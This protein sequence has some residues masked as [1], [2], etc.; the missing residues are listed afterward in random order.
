MSTRTW[1][2]EPP[3][4]RPASQLAGYTLGAA[5]AVLLWLAVY[6]WLAWRLYVAGSAPAAALNLML[7]ALLIVSGV[8]LALV[9]WEIVRRWWRQ[10][11]PAVWGALSLRQMQALTPSEF[12][13]YVA[14]RLFVRQGYH[15]VNTP[16]VKDGGVDVILTDRNGSRAVVQCKR[17]KGTVGEE[18]VRDLYGTMMHADAE[19][20]YLVTTGMISP[21]AYRWAVG[22]PIELIDG[23]RLVELAR[24]VPHNE[25]SL[26]H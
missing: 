7:A 8:L 2:F 25:P 17:Y 6:T 9:W 21:A 1:A 13:E 11:R 16:D 24:S 19:R 20:A 12:E 10:I 3:R 18:I 14:Q 22:K 26:P 23:A 4:W 15:A 5:G